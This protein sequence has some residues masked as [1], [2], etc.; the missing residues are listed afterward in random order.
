MFYGAK[1]RN[2]MFLHVPKTG[3]GIDVELK[4]D[5]ISGLDGD[6]NHKITQ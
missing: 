5:G 3:G 1:N 4:R 2:C 6:P